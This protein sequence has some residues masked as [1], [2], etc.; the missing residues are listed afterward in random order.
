MAEE[1]TGVKY[2]DAAAT[3]ALPYSPVVA[4]A[5]I[6]RI[7]PILAHSPKAPRHGEWRKAV[8]Q[9]HERAREDCK[10]GGEAMKWTSTEIP[11]LPH[12]RAAKAGD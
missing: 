6:R 7:P 5:Y 1:K 3:V 9:A 4:R 11:L 12:P 2:K 8:L 10:E